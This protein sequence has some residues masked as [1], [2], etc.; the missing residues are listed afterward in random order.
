MK[1]FYYAVCLYV[2]CVSLSH[3][4]VFSTEGFE[5]LNKVYE[6]DQEPTGNGTDYFGLWKDGGSKVSQK[7]QER[8]AGGHSIVLEPIEANYQ[9]ANGNPKPFYGTFYSK[10][11]DFSQS[12]SVSIDFNH[13]VTNS[14]INF[15]NLGNFAVEVSNKGGEPGSFTS[16]LSVDA[17]GDRVVKSSS[18]QWLGDELKECLLLILPPAIETCRLIAKT[19]H[20]AGLGA[21]DT[22]EYW[23][24]NFVIIPQELLSKNTVIRFKG[25]LNTAFP[26]TKVF[27]DE[28][29]ISYDGGAPEF[30]E[31]TISP[32]NDLPHPER[33]AYDHATFDTDDAAGWG[34]WK[35]GGR[36]AYTTP[37]L[38]EQN[39]NVAL[40]DRY[41][42]G[43]SNGTDPTTGESLGDHKPN[44][45]SIYTA[46]TD[47]TRAQSLQLE[48]SFV[49]YG[50]DIAD[51]DSFELSISTN[52]GVDFT[53]VKKWYA[54]K[55]FINLKR[56]NA[57]VSIP[58][59]L[60]STRKLTTT[61]I[62]RIQ[63]KG[64]DIRDQV[65]IDNVKVF[66]VG[67]Q[68]SPAGTPLNLNWSSF[69]STETHLAANPA[70][71]TYDLINS[72]LIKNYSPGNFEGANGEVPNFP[73]IYGAVEHTDLSHPGHGPHITQ[74]FDNTLGTNVF[75]FDIHQ[76]DHR[77]FKS[78]TDRAVATPDTDR[79]RTDGK[80]N[81]RQRVEIKAYAESHDHQ[82]ATEGETHF[83]AW[84]FKI[85]TGFQ[86]SDKFT[87]LH[88]LKPKGGPNA[89]MPLITLS[90][91][92][93][94]NEVTY[95]ANGNVISTVESSP[96]VLN[97]RYSP[98]T[99]PQVTIVS[100]PL[101]E[102][103]G[104]WVQV[105]EKVT[106]GTENE[107]RYEL[108]ITD[109]FNLEAKPIMAFSS[110]SLPTWKGGDFVRAKWGIYRSIV[111][112]DK[113]RD[114]QIQFADF[115]ISE[116]NAPNAQYGSLLDFGY[117]VNSLTGGN[118]PSVPTD[119]YTWRYD[120]TAADD[121]VHIRQ[122]V[123]SVEAVINGV[124][125]KLTTTQTRRL[126]ISVAGGNDSV[127][128]DEDV[129]YGTLEIKGGAGNDT[130]V[131]GRGNDK[132]YG[133]AGNDIIV[134]GAGND[135]LRGSD[136]EDTIIGGFGQDDVNGN[137]GDDTQLSDNRDIVRN[138]FSN[139]MITNVT[140]L[141]D[142]PKASWF[143]SQSSYL[144]RH[145]LINGQIE[146][147]SVVTDS[148][149]RMTL[150]ST[151]GLDGYPTFPVVISDFSLS[152]FSYRSIS[153]E[154]Y[155]Y[156]ESNNTDTAALNNI[157]NLLSSAPDT[158][159]IYALWRLGKISIARAKR[160]YNFNVKPNI[161][162]SQPLRYGTQGFTVNGTDYFTPSTVRLG[163]GPEQSAETRASWL[164]Q[165]FTFVNNWT[166][167]TFDYLA[168]VVGT[169]VE[170]YV[171][172]QTLQCLYDQGIDL[173]NLLSNYDQR[174]ADISKEGWISGCQDFKTMYNYVQ[175][176]TGFVDK[177][178]SG[179]IKLVPELIDAA[180]KLES[181]T[182]GL[183]QFLDLETPT[184]NGSAGSNTTTN[185][186][187]AAAGD[188]KS[189]TLFGAADSAKLRRVDM[190][191]VY[192][193]A[194]TKLI[195]LTCQDCPRL[196]SLVDNINPSFLDDLQF[197]I[198]LTYPR[199]Y[200]DGRHEV[201]IRLR[202]I[203][204]TGVDLD[205]PFNQEYLALDAGIFG[206]KEFIFR[207]S[208]YPSRGESF[209]TSTLTD[210]IYGSQAGIAFPDATISPITLI[211]TAKNWFSSNV[212]NVADGASDPGSIDTVLDG[213]RFDDFTVLIDSVEAAQARGEQLVTNVLDG[214]LSHQVIR[215]ALGSIV[216]QVRDQVGGTTVVTV[217]RLANDIAAN[218][219]LARELLQLVGSQLGIPR[220]TVTYNNDIVDRMRWWMTLALSRMVNHAVVLDYDDLVAAINDNTGLFIRP[221][222]SIN[223][224]VEMAAVMLGIEIPAGQ[225]NGLVANPTLYRGIKRFAELARHFW[226]E[227][228]ISEGL[229]NGG[230]S[231]GLA[232][233]YDLRALGPQAGLPI[234]ADLIG[235]VTSPLAVY[236]VGRK[237]NWPASL[238]ALHVAGNVGIAAADFALVAYIG[239]ES[240]A[241]N[242]GYIGGNINFAPANLD[243]PKIPFAGEDSTSKFRILFQYSD[244]ILGFEISPRINNK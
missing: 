235:A 5:T 62:L 164:Q 203:D 148:T 215:L 218:P 76:S 53:P 116:I 143:R 168:A 150:S 186:A 19:K 213:T 12:S 17:S 112:G 36:N 187:Q 101:S 242:S 86:A 162:A 199:I 134:G 94:K 216:S 65:Y 130:I 24:S 14:N 31:D 91:A 54:G 3:A 175:L 56:Y 157:N 119:K 167:T 93:A 136:G 69:K 42:E 68:A 217:Q 106:F 80:F 163:L 204:F 201:E 113:L 78:D 88:Q 182:S 99:A 109:P 117:Y 83:M 98:T 71:P 128:V 139:T 61:T 90:A 166:Q 22:R 171:V 194:V 72:T 181:N 183:V 104:K 89:R 209:T 1:S 50:M 21:D 107:G 160:L 41:V 144:R 32:Q 200:G 37:F 193:V 47:F 238:T 96:A 48:F 176:M 120:G 87:H 63:A 92:A 165:G 244:T 188:P 172:K 232:H 28:V 212:S 35:D 97:L 211:K 219:A 43:K 225:L 66:T 190:S 51:N 210:V 237:L 240:K 114:E 59:N 58:G 11:I 153:H 192:Y 27:F 111:Q 7:T 196:T 236:L 146:Q 135:I 173:T 82:L 205:G 224:V 137:A 124:A 149:G 18:S 161:S 64:K 177:V 156:L 198:T 77:P 60:T 52:A 231:V 57:I 227:A 115:V 127:I 75:A 220:G 122:G 108:L 44:Y 73:C 40:R 79:C 16:V 234:A 221:N 178:E 241:A 4:A 126:F 158:Y 95:D 142:L 132:L 46:N 195:E 179:D 30:S 118:A 129:D 147:T 20:G 207:Q 26:K 226:N 206:V 154:I 214:P 145:Q 15:E 151:V 174:N 202:A 10:P 67:S 223:F 159:G 189:S 25:Y 121:T 102:L 105:L 239:D 140:Q 228:P 13:I 185:N 155:T 74:L 45:S 170:L 184:N 84:R 133:E 208:W 81:D 8:Y 180:S 110:Y 6:L 33:V 233:S 191:A 152:D 55:D 138:D 229:I 85:P 9:D 34:I 243:L 49:G 39:R 29:T 123:D 169:E 131:G 222:E 2:S 230:L 38:A 100:A 197:R 125:Q 103:E 70:T 23:N 141:P